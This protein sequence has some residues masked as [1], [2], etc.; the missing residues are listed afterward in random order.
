MNWDDSKPREVGIFGASKTL[1]EKSN[2]GVKTVVSCTTVF[3]YVL[4]LLKIQHVVN[5]LVK[6]SPV[7]YCSVVSNMRLLNQKIEHHRTYLVKC[8]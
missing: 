2:T 7:V 5:I 1:D 4:L 3:T 6:T 8:Y